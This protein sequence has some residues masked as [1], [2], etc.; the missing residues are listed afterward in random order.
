M[1]VP[2]LAFWLQKSVKDISVQ[3]ILKMQKEAEHLFW[4]QE[5]KSSQS[6]GDKAWS[7]R[8]L[9]TFGKWLALSF[10]YRVKPDVVLEDICL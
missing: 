8:R 1:K 10:Y 7:I 9:N 2:K 5:T 4:K 3:T 6:H